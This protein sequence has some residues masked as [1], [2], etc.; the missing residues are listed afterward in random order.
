MEW[1]LMPYRRYAEFDGRSRRR[2]FWSFMLFYWLVF[3]ALNVLFGHPQTIVSPGGVRAYSGLTGIPAIIGSLFALA[4]IIPHLAV[5]VRRLHDQNRTGWLLLLY[6]IPVLGWFALLVLF[7]L[8]GNQG[9]NR[10]GP[11][12]KQPYDTGAF[13]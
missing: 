12:P 9:P 7:L 6:L 11:D 8:D 4:S 3:V 1:M 5:G 10:Y 2:E 13:S